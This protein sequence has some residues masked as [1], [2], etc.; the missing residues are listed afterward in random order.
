MVS[1][2]V[3][4]SVVVGPWNAEPSDVPNELCHKPEVKWIKD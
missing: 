2:L 3:D 4:R 1:V